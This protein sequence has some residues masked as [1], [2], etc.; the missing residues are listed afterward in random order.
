M[1]ILINAA[2]ALAVDAKKQA[3]GEALSKES[4]QGIYDSSGTEAM[5][6][7]M[8]KEGIQA[9]RN[10]FAWYAEVLPAD[11]S[12]TQVVDWGAGVGRF[13]PL[14]KSR[15][16]EKINLV[17]PSPDSFSV[18]KAKFQDDSRVALFHAPLGGPVSR[19]V[20]ASKTIHTCTFVVNCVGSLEKA[21]DALSATV[22][23]GERLFVVTN[24]FA[25][26]A[27]VDTIKDNEL[28][29]AI[30][31]GFFDVPPAEYRLPSAKTF[32]NVIV[33]TGEVLTDA[34]HTTAEYAQ[35]WKTESARWGVVSAKLMLPDGFVHQAQPGED[36]GDYRFA[37][38]AM[39]LVRK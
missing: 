22:S 20:S 35:L 5:R 10:I 3:C 31:I 36:F 39:E 4:P 6:H 24:V 21:F 15:N 37:V 14:F 33:G 26:R 30:S 18:L 19:N 29:S 32:S 16:A 38:L 23:P 2:N 8:D 34:V 12:S 11:L 1:T 9:D 27:L 7:L 28:A 25:P 13:V 17:E